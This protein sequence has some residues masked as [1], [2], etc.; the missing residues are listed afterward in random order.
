[1]PGGLPDGRS[2]SAG[3]LLNKRHIA[4]M[5]R[6]LF[7]VLRFPLARH[8]GG[9]KCRHSSCTLLTQDTGI[10]KNTFSVLAY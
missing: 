5:P 2:Q 10:M 1:M 9:D 3:G 4:P 8:A 7:F 6:A